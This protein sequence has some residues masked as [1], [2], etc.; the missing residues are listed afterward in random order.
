M[1]E[2]VL[3]Y[4]TVRQL[5]LTYFVDDFIRDCLMLDFKLNMLSW[6]LITYRLSPIFFPVEG[7]IYFIINRVK[8]NIV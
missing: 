5:H 2:Y 6:R 8:N 3:G 4:Q 7:I 1:F